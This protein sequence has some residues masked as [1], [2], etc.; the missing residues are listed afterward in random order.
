MAVRLEVRFEV[1]EKRESFEARKPRKLWK[2]RGLSALTGVTSGIGVLLIGPNHFRSVVPLHHPT[3]FVS[4]AS[5]KY[6]LYL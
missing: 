2:L 1:V 6:F 3:Q 4:F 5:T